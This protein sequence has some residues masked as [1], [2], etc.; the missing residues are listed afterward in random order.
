MIRAD[1]INRVG[2][3]YL[4]SNIENG[5]FSYN[6][7][8]TEIGENINDYANQELKKTHQYIDLRFADNKLTVLIETKDNFDR[9]NKREIEQQLQQ[10]VY[11]EKVL[12]GNKIVA[13]LAN[14]MDDRIRVWYG[15]N[16]NIDLDDYVKNERKIKSFKEY[17][18]I[19]FSNTNNKLKVIQ[20]TY[21]LN[22]LLHKYGINEK[23]RSQF[24]GTC[25][26][27]LKNGLSYSDN[28]LT[29]TQIIAGI[30]ENLEKLLNN[31]LNKAIKLVLLDK[32]V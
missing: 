8:L 3:E 29:T 31:N 28:N 7:S 14:T 11:Y 20:N 17:E 23:I 1:I 16:I 2:R 26:L 25:L 18:N 32:N 19:Y 30:K 10:Y 5:E 9:W 4:T 6:K 15:D 21:D 24:V 22:E 12:T 13:I 27:A